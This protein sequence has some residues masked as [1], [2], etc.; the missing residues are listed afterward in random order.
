MKR[1]IVPGVID[2]EQALCCLPP[3][4]TA[5]DAA[6]LM[7]ERRVGAVMIVDGSRLLGIVTERDLVFRLLAEGRDARGTRLAEI[8]TA[9]PETL[10]PGDSA[11][12]ALQK[13]LDGRYRHLPVVD[14]SRIC[15]IVSIRDLYEAA[16]LTLQEELRSAESLIYGEQ[17]GATAS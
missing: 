3:D 16:R 1:R 11:L 12:D 9:G 10:S 7:R 15:G 6:T 8:M 14:G 5:H 2:G 4:A 17:Y 13:M